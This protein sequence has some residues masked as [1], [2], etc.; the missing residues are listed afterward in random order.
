MSRSQHVAIVGG[1]GSGKTWLAEQVANALAPHAVR[2]SLDEFYRDL[3]PLPAAER[4]GVN[5]DDPA[6][7]DWDALRQVMDRMRPGEPVL[8]PAYDFATHTRRPELRAF[9]PT[10]LVIWDGL[11]LLHPEWLRERFVTSIFVECP[12]EVRLA[13]RAERDLRE[14]G[15]S[16]ESVHQQF[17]AHVEP[18]HQKF[19][20]PQSLRARRTLPSPPSTQAI[21][22][23]LL[24]L[25]LL[26]AQP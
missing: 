5:F 3:S 13:R 12:T 10:R 21:D 15:R 25:K 26:T 8:L 11:W 24:E 19:V 17:H 4:E 20:T 22:E 1:S 23:L 7:I 2:V 6:A 14:R 9:T 18:M 16:R